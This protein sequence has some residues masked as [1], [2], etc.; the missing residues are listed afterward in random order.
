MDNEGFNEG[1]RVSQ[2]GYS[3]VLMRGADGN[4][5]VWNGSSYVLMTSNQTTIGGVN[6]QI[7]VTNRINF[8]GGGYASIGNPTTVG[9][10]GA[11]IV[12]GNPPTISTGMGPVW[13]SVFGF[14]PNQFNISMGGF[15]LTAGNSNGRWSKHYNPNEELGWRNRLVVMGTDATGKAKQWQYDSEQLGAL[16]AYETNGAI[17]NHAFTGSGNGYTSD[18]STWPA[19]AS[20]ANGAT[21]WFNTAPTQAAPADLTWQPQPTDFDQ[22]PLEQH[23]S[24]ASGPSR[25]RL[26]LSAAGRLLSDLSEEQSARLSIMQWHRD[27]ERPALVRYV[28]AGII[29][30]TAEL[31]QCPR[32]HRDARGWE[33]GHPPDESEPAEFLSPLPGRFLPH[34][35]HVS[36]NQ[37]HQLPQPGDRRSASACSAAARRDRGLLQVG[38]EHRRL[39]TRVQRRHGSQRHADVVPQF[40]RARRGERWPSPAPA[41]ACTL[42]DQGGYAW[43]FGDSDTRSNWC[44]SSL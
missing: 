38:R 19:W 23:P 2:G 6:V 9:I 17:T 41:W 26:W 42:R 36:P 18:S 5:Y 3:Q 30:A 34:C 11:Q 10:G 29:T 21:P 24:F 16:L 31:L 43:Q 7:N 1:V 40:A 12:L 15:S 25:P 37:R 20:T 22:T 44:Q 14:N 4:I 32:V 28:T 13:I 33:F 35:A 8:A 39:E 27:M